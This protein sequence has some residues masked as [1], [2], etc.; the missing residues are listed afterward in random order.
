MGQGRQTSMMTEGYI[1]WTVSEGG[2]ALGTAMPGFKDA[3][4]E[5]ER[6]Q[7]ILFMSNDFKAK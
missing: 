5:K 3:L 4:S 1:Y 6:W 2:E 7:L